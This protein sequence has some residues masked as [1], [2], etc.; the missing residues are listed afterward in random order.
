MNSFALEAKLFSIMARTKDFDENEVLT[1][2]MN[3]FWSRGYGATSMEDLVNELGISRSSLYDTYTD[4][5][6]LFIKALGNYQ[7]MGAEKIKEIAAHPGSAKDTVKKLIELSIGGF[8]DGKHRKG[9]FLVNAGVEVAPHDKEVNNLVCRNDQEM[10]EVFYQVIQKGKK[11]G[12]IKNP[13]D[14]RSLARFIFN[15]VKGLQ[16]TS[17]SASHKSVVDDIIQLALSTLD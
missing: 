7:H 5:H 14:A 13:R 9:C 12:E 11:K 16:V 17:K 15:T 2:A 10:E 6:T 8:L 3:L 1:R 4:K